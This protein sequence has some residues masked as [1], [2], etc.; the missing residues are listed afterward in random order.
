[1]YGR[2]SRPEDNHPAGAP[3]TEWLEAFLPI[4]EAIIGLTLYVDLRPGDRYGWVCDGDPENGGYLDEP[5]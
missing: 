1:M 3:T 5:R 4:S 2:R